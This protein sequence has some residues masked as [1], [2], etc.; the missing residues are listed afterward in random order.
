MMSLDILQKLCIIENMNKGNLG[1][2]F[3]RQNLNYLTNSKFYNLSEVSPR[4]IPFNNSL[5][6][7]LKEEVHLQKDLTLIPAGEVPVEIFNLDSLPKEIWRHRAKDEKKIPF[8]A[9]RYQME[10]KNASNSSWFISN[11]HPFRDAN[12]VRNSK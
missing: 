6:P 4:L 1:Q 2:V 8:G 9:Q 12:R 3:H 11:Q 10:V 5:N 7:N